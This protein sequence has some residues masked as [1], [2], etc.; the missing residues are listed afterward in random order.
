MRLMGDRGR[1]DVARIQTW[2]THGG[3]LD[4]TAGESEGRECTALVAPD[5]SGLAPLTTN[6][7]TTDEQYL[8]ELS[9]LLDQTNRTLVRDCDEG[10]VMQFYTDERRAE[11]RAAT[12]RLTI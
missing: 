11:L 4:G 1:R 3:D 7:G 6:A 9:E 12:S 8:Q 2:S 5:G 10:V